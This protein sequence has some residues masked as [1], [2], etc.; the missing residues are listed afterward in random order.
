MPNQARVYEAAKKT[1]VA[2]RCWR[3]GGSDEQ[4]SAVLGGKPDKS[5]SVIAG[6]RGTAIVGPCLLIAASR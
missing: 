6:E 2:L 3:D 5:K 1:R 4:I